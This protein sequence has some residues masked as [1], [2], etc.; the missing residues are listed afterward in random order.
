MEIYGYPATWV[1]YTRVKGT[2]LRAVNKVL[3]S[4]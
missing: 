2:N 1:G 4:Y 3:Q